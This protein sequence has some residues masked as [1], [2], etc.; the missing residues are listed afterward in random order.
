MGKPGKSTFKGEELGNQYGK[1]DIERLGLFSEMPFMNGKG[2]VSPFPKPRPD[3][4]RNLLAGG[5]KVKTDWQD[6]YFDKE[7]KR[8][9][10]GEALKGRGKKP[11][12]S[13]FK[14]VSERPF[15]PTGDTKKHSTPGDW[16]GTFEGH[17]DAFSNKLRPRPPF[18]HEPANP[19]TNPTKKGGPGYVNICINPYPEHS[20]EKYGV[21]PKFKQYGQLLD[22]PMITGTHPQP[23]FETNPYRDPEK[24]KPGPTYAPLNV[25]EFPLLP[26]GKFIPT[27]PAKLPGGCK[28]GCFEKYPEYK[29][30]KYRSILETMKPLRKAGGS[31]L[32]PSYGE[33]T[34]YTCSVVNENLRFRVNENNYQVYKPTFT[35]H[36][37]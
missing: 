26:P 2:Y 29:S 18:K 34:Y 14:N 13:A 27:G 10:N 25:K 9:F 8:I 12:P 6:C 22:G 15:I 23:Y 19:I 3:K 20:V 33:K 21:K 36:L 4:G 1:P 16:Y 37:L 30:D 11:K 7:F 17:L 31:F 24:F 32:P 5:S 28:A 35:K